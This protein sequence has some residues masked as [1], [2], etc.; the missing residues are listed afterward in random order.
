MRLLQHFVRVDARHFR[1]L[2]VVWVVLTIWSAVMVGSSEWGEESAGRVLL[3]AAALLEFLVSVA[4]MGIL[5]A[6]VVQQH[7]P[8]GTTAWW[9]TRPLDPRTLLGSR[10][11][12]IALLFVALP[13]ICDAVVMAFFRMPAGQIALVLL[14]WSLIRAAVMVVLMSAA[15][16]TRT[17]SGFLI[18]VGACLLAA[19]ALVNVA[20]LLA[21]SN[22]SEAVLR[23]SSELAVGLFTRRPDPTAVVL[24]WA[25]VLGTGL[26]LLHTQ[27][28][29]RSVRRAAA[30]GVTGVIAA[31]LI[32]LAW[33][34]PLLHAEPSAP[35]W[36]DQLD[37][38]APPQALYFDNGGRVFNDG[39]RLRTA[40]ARMYLTGVPDGLFAMVRMTHGVLELDGRRLTG[41]GGRHFATLPASEGDPGAVTRALTQ[42]LGVDQI[43]GGGSRRE[44]AAIMTV[45]SGEVPTGTAAATF[46][47]EFDI[48]L[49]ELQQAAI[50]PLAAGASF[51][52]GAYRL[53]IRNYRERE[54][55]PELTV[56]ISRATSSFDRQPTQAYSFYLRNRQTR[57][58]LSG[59][60]Q[61]GLSVTRLPEQVVL[62]SSA[63]L[64]TPHGF[65]VQPG[66]IRFPT[67]TNANLRSAVSKPVSDETTDTTWYRDAELVVIRTVDRGTVRRSLQITGLTFNTP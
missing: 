47:G 49:R 51:Q 18:L 10:L 44:T 6:R 54:G 22:S 11:L 24:A 7:S 45:M 23:M 5:V 25:V 38:S 55:G 15:A 67:P 48:E 17:I 29:R 19:A 31:A 28:V 26:L 16:L 37:L 9:L 14:E 33:P 61:D 13:A 32:G 58:A 2:I 62:G 41:N 35:Q 60:L 43:G 34:W 4:L 57:E 1:G 3:I 12:L 8:V 64:Y 46:N 56:R 50:L 63:Y 27:Y 21:I 20:F 40:Y 30:I 36:A 65:F 53:A 66:V 39:S 59:T 52:D 42:V